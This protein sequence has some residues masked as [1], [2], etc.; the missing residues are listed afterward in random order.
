[1]TRFQQ[2]L[3]GL[4]I[5]RFQISGNYRILSFSKQYTLTTD[6]LLRFIPSD[7]LFISAED[8]NQKFGLPHLFNAESKISESIVNKE[9][10]ST[11]LCPKTGDLYISIDG[12]VI[13]L[14]ADSAG[15][16]SYQFTGPNDL[17][18]VGIG[19]KV[20]VPEADINLNKMQNNSQHT[21][22]IHA[23]LPKFQ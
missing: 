18:I 20:V 13:Q 16:E 12:G 1:M 2:I 7:G 10:Q 21:N 6:S 22:L 9:I 19:A 3:K 15:Y 5:Q 17:T 11:D 4:I 23:R 14:I 8:H